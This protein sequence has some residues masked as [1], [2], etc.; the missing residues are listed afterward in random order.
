LRKI[1]T[2]MYLSEG[3]HWIRFKELNPLRDANAD[4]LKTKYFGFDY[5]ELVP[6]KIISDPSKPEDRH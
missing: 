1:I 3:E 5:I 2:R 6:L 4:L